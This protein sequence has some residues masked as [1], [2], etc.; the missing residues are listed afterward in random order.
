M[1][2]LWAYTHRC[3]SSYSPVANRPSPGCTEE[4]VPCVD[5]FPRGERATA[6]AIQLAKMAVTNAIE[7]C[8]VC[9]STSTVLY[10]ACTSTSTSASLGRCAALEPSSTYRRT[11]WNPR[12]ILGMSALFRPAS[13]S[14]GVGSGISLGQ[15]LQYTL[16]AAARWKQSA[17]RQRLPPPCAMQFAVP[18][19]AAAVVQPTS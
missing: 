6:S 3:T 1:L 18:P 9:T 16:R 7:R 19:G 8:A 10:A 2:Y 4:R 5:H 14:H 13:Y 12:T 15:S 17:C 11:A